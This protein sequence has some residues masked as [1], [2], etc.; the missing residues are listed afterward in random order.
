MTS[1]ARP[2][3]LYVKIL[4]PTKSLYEGDAISISAH[5]R[6][7]PFDVLVGHTNFFSILTPSEVLLDTGVKQQRFPVSHGLMKVHNNIVT[8][9]VDIGMT[10]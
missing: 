7:G 4:S 5:N 2:E 9:Y 6:V 10:P 8:L 1:R 3:R